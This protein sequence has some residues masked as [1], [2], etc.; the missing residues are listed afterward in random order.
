MKRART[1]TTVRRDMIVY[2]IRLI[3]QIFSMYK[4]EMRS[5][6]IMIVSNE[7]V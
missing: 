2:S 1:A 5:G 6:N 7:D 4:F 3:I